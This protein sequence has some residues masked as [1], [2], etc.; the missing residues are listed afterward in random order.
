MGV[1]SVPHP[2]RLYPR[3]RPGT[4][5]TGGCVGPATVWTDGKSRPNRDSIP[6]R[7]ARGQSL[8]WLSYP[9]HGYVLVLAL[10][11]EEYMI[12]IGLN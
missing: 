8:Y 12:G 1:G 9:A 2:G 6:D 11:Y 5:F 4:H 7:P 10:Q 3:E